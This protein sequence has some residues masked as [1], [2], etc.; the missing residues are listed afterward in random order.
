MRDMFS[1]R[2]AIG[3]GILLLTC[4]CSLETTLQRAEAQQARP[5]AGKAPTA[6]EQAVR[7]AAQAYAKAY[8][9][10]DAKAL[11]ALWTVDGDY[12]DEAGREFRGRAEIEKLFTATFAAESHMRLEVQTDSV[13]FL[14]PDVAIETGTA[15]AIPA[16]GNPTSARYSAVQVKRDGNWLLASVHDSGRVAESNSE[17]LRG[18][19]WLVG[20]WQS[21]NGDQRLTVKVEWIGNKNFLSRTF[22]TESGGKVQRTGTQIIGWD[23]RAGEIFSWHFDSDGSF[24]RDRWNKQG[25]RWFIETQGVL[26]SGAGSSSTNILTPIDANTFS[27]QSADRMVDGAALPDTEAVKLTRVE[28]RR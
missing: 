19:D 10:G 22:S 15:W 5:T 9:A 14:S 7:A 2:S 17:Y 8:N 3:L 21:D 27:W 13:R 11:A 23:P 24:G 6:D 16:H 1:G 20:Q 28:T 12:T 4:S 26:R 18:L 25:A